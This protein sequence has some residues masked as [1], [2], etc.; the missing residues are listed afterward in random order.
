MKD[1]I[2]EHWENGIGKIVSFEGE[3]LRILFHT[4]GEVIFAPSQHS[5]LKKLD[6]SGFLAHFYEDENALRLLIEEASPDIVK[7]LII[8]NGGE[9][10]ERNQIKK[11]LGKS[12]DSV[13]GWRKNLCFI[14]DEDWS[15]WWSKVRKKISKDPSFDTSTK[16]IIAVNRTDI[17]S[18]IKKFNKKL[19]AP[20]KLS[21]AEQIIDKDEESCGDDILSVINSVV[22]ENL[23]SI[24]TDP[25]ALAIA[26]IVYIKLN[27][28]D[29]LT[30]N[31]DNVII[32][33][34]KAI[35]SGKLDAKKTK[36]AYDY[37]L[38]NEQQEFFYHFIIYLFG[39]PQTKKMIL[40]NIKKLSFTEN[41]TVPNEAHKSIPE[42]HFELLKWLCL[43]KPNELQQKHKL[44]DLDESCAKSKHLKDFI[45]KLYQALLTLE[46][47]DI[48][49]DVIAS[50]VSKNNNTAVMLGYLNIL[51]K[52]AK[53]S[54]EYVVLFINSFSLDQ[55]VKIL[56]GTVFTNEVAAGNPV[57]FE[58][59]I[60]KIESGDMLHGISNIDKNKLFSKAY[61]SMPQDTS[62]KIGEL[63]TKI[64]KLL[65]REDIIKHLDSYTN[66]KLDEM[67]MDKSAFINDR[68]T[69]I[70]LLITRNNRDVVMNSG[71]KLAAHTAG[72]D[73]QLLREITEKINDNKYSRDLV[74]ILIERVLHD[75]VEKDNLIQFIIQTRCIDILVDVFTNIIYLVPE[76]QKPLLEEIINNN[77]IAPIFVRQILVEMVA[78]PD[79]KPQLR[80]NISRYFSEAILAAIDEAAA[81]VINSQTTHKELY[82]ELNKS[83][84]TELALSDKYMEDRVTDA[85]SKTKQRY[86]EYALSLKSTFGLLKKLDTSFNEIAL[87]EIDDKW[88][89]DISN[90]IRMMEEDIALFLNKMN[91][92]Y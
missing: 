15:K 59:V 77:K 56:P 11:L 82:Q 2:V 27:Q 50:H 89:S 44:A 57:L 68:I 17:D 33:V 19:K 67:I 35:T 16:N 22:L 63:R 41:Q 72:D 86:E 1:D 4:Q 43:L 18:L 14:T 88:I 21:I 3:G 51:D 66:D 24:D 74:K 87:K 69:A 10:I 34:V 90:K 9:E 40:K 75:S 60:C 37:L 65:K 71:K 81:M 91:I 84:Q 30:N 39:T 48:L 55:A 29:I 23:N 13:V 6:P 85:I 25:A 78:S 62:E 47:L 38:T 8:D 5:S 32:L 52:I 36:I 26:V 70:E 53:P 79:Q 45:T 20:E 92:N 42:D 28:K 58:S 61:Q 49:R 76:E 12:P 73:W 80:I 54:T 83:H 7:L 64:I 46:S 31:I